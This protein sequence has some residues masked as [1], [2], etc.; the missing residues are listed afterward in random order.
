MRLL[1]ALASVVVL[2][3]ASRLNANDHPDPVQFHRSRPT[4]LLASL[5]AGEDFEVVAVASNHPFEPQARTAVARGQYPRRSFFKFQALGLDFH[6]DMEQNERLFHPHYVEEEHDW[7]NGVRVDAGLPPERMSAADLAANNCF[8][9]GNLRSNNASA[10]SG[11]WLAASTCWNGIRGMIS[12]HSGEVF[13]IAP[14]HLHMSE[15]EV[16]FHEQRLA[17]VHQTLATTVGAGLKNA[18]PVHVVYRLDASTKKIYSILAHKMATLGKEVKMTSVS[19]GSAADE[20]AASSAPKPTGPLSWCGVGASLMESD[21]DTNSSDHTLQSHDGHVHAH[22]HDGTEH[23]HGHFHEQSNRRYTQ[24]LDE[25]RSHGAKPQATLTKTIGL[26][27]VN[28]YLRKTAKPSYSPAQYTTPGRG[29]QPYLFNSALLGPCTDPNR[30]ECDS[31]DLINIVAAIY[32]FQDANIVGT[33]SLPS[34]SKTGFVDSAQN[35]NN[36]VIQLVGQISMTSADPWNQY[37][38]N[39]AWAPG[40][41]GVDNL[42]AAFHCWR[43]CCGSSSA[44]GS[45]AAQPA[46]CAPGTARSTQYMPPYDNAH[47]L[48]GQKFQLSVL[49]YAGVGTMCNP[50]SS[51][52]I[53]MTNIAAHSSYAVTTPLGSGD[54]IVADQVFNARIIAH[55]IGHNLGMQH[56]NNVASGGGVAPNVCDPSGFVMNAIVSDDPTYASI[57]A[58]PGAGANGATTYAPGTVFSTCSKAYYKAWTGNGATCL[59]DLPTTSWGNATCGNG[60]IEL[61]EDCDGGIA[62]TDPCCTAQCKY[63]AGSTCSSTQPCCNVVGNVCTPKTDTTAV[64]RAG[65]GDCDLT[66]YCDGVTATCNVNFV[67]GA[68]TSCTDDQGCSGGC[69]NGLCATLCSSCKRSGAT[70]TGAPWTQCS[71]SSSSTV[72]CSSFLCQS[73]SGGSCYN[74]YGSADGSSGPQ[75]TPAG[76]PCSSGRQCDGSGTC[77][78]ST[79][80]NPGILWRAGAWQTCTQCGGLQERSVTCQYIDNLGQLRTIEDEAC[81]PG[82][83][84]FETRTC[85]NL[86]SG[87]TGAQLG[88]FSSLIDFGETLSAAFGSAD[89][90]AAIRSYVP[91]APMY[92]SDFSFTDYSY[93]KGVFVI[94]FPG[95]VLFTITL[96]I[97]IAYCMCPRCRDRKIELPDV[98]DEMN[99]TP[100]QAEEAAML[101]SKSKAWP[102]FGLIAGTLLATAASCIALFFCQQV[103]FGILD[104]QAGASVLAL[105]LVDQAIG[106]GTVLTTPFG[107][108]AVYL[109]SALAAFAPS[110]QQ[111]AT[112]IAPLQTTTSALSAL[113]GVDNATLILSGTG[114]QHWPCT[115]TCQGLKPKTSVNTSHAMLSAFYNSMTTSAAAFAA[116][117]YIVNTANGSAH[118]TSVLNTLTTLPIE[119]APGRQL[120]YQATTYMQKT[121]IYLVPIMICILIFPLLSFIFAGLFGAGCCRRWSHGILGWNDKC[122]YVFLL[123]MWLFVALAIPAMMVTGDSCLYLNRA[124]LDM[125]GTLGVS[126]ITSQLLSACLADTSMLAA[127]N[128]SQMLQYAQTTLPL[129]PATSALYTSSAITSGL[130]EYNTYYNSFQTLTVADFGVVAKMTSLNTHCGTALPTDGSTVTSSNPNA[131]SAQCLAARDEVVAL[132]DALAAA[133][134]A[135]KTPANVNTYINDAN[136]FIENDITYD[137]AQ[138]Y[139]RIMDSGQ[140]VINNAYCG[141]LGDTYRTTKHS[142]CDTTVTG[143]SWLAMIFFVLALL[144]ILMIC[145]SLKL[146]LYLDPRLSQIAPLK[147][148]TSKEYRT[149]GGRSYDADYRETTPVYDYDAD[150][151][152]SMEALMR[153]PTFVHQSRAKQHEQMHALGRDLAARKQ[154]HHLKQKL[155]KQTPQQQTAQTAYG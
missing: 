128:T 65:N 100:D 154:Q 115:T 124:E 69:Y 119:V 120:V 153:D 71:S 70:M 51:G 125:H 87:C 103:K 14:A 114:G 75:K 131:G 94:T 152:A 72:S 9:H 81:S 11:G 42:L 23:S 89:K 110:F 32:K 117:D 12:H 123:L 44:Y 92:S 84:P 140:T 59:N 5:K 3:T 68:G 126:V 77:D 31:A 112:A 118:I 6:G 49:G 47:L 43:T 138:K 39:S 155:R 20:F 13:G 78:F 38:G 79:N 74:F 151:N 142:W 63:T 48:S 122:T 102:C 82:A 35:N 22:V 146:K 147:V 141:D 4:F 101:R 137:G 56:D 127:T 33:C 1:L 130:A 58:N 121:T 24:V 149:K 143:I 96:L 107:M 85:I 40:D 133:K 46:F 45:Y 144:A 52:G 90:A 98:G 61:G 129:D 113:Y 132:K 83:K 7:V 64:C 97:G 34:C 148:V 28:D 27:I 76:V 53:D 93:F 95:L 150:H 62:L 99:A 80:L 91:R 21:Y 111:Q 105:E 50:G 109:S 108:L 116:S 41:V 36:I 37:T 17:P 10:P 55:E 57:H 67:K 104:S 73:A 106:L 136:S 25:P 60:F 29:A 88:T 139:D 54:Q 8:Y 26:L 16:A 145:S 30:V 86:A 2:A 134:A 66:E 15:R 135:L 19:E 18:P